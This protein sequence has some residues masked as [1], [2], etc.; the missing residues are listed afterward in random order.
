MQV[1]PAQ[2]EDAQAIAEIHVH[3]WQVAYPGIVPAEYLASLSVEKYEAMWHGCIV[4]GKPQLMVATE[5][6]RVLGWV[7]FGPSRDAGVGTNVA[8]IWAIYVGAANWGRG[9]GRQLWKHA[10]KNMQEQG[11]TS[12]G[13]WAFPENTRA[14]NFYRSLGFEVE[15][16]SSKQFELSGSQLNEVRY[17]RNTD[18]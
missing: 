4:A 3:T 7:A 15:A 10:R 18:A 11:F 5:A 17:V 16:S 12:V 2:V 8:E 9:V 1:R 13:L 14:G 6:D